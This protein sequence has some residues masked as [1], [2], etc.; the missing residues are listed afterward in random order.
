MWPHLQIIISKSSASEYCK[1]IS[2]TTLG[3]HPD[4]ESEHVSLYSEAL[5]RGFCWNQWEKP[6][7]G[8]CASDSLC[9]SLSFTHLDLCNVSGMAVFLRR[10]MLFIIFTIPIFWLRTMGTIGCCCWVFNASTTL[11]LVL[12]G[13]SPSSEESDGDVE[14]QVSCTVCHWT[15]PGRLASCVSK[16]IHVSVFIN[17]AE[18]GKRGVNDFGGNRRNQTRRAK[19]L[20]PQMRFSF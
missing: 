2:A 7:L 9:L 11:E 4:A 16:D 20:V 14:S 12:T 3:E 13:Q 8:V 5:K 17:Y 19:W 15:T 10:S 6:R 18:V 1:Y